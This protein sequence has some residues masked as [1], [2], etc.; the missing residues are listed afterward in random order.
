MGPLVTLLLDP[1]TLPT[2][3]ALATA[4]TAW[5]RAEAAAITARHAINRTGGP[6]KTPPGG[7]N[8]PP[9]GVEMRRRP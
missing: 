1:R 9:G 2:A 8:K 6:R 3:I 7:P 5:L 4:L